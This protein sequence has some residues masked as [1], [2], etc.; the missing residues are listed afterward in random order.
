M[1]TGLI[2]QKLGMSAHFA[3]NGQHIPV[4]V[5]K[6]DNCQVVAQRTQEKDGYTAV[7]LGVG[8]AKVK[9]VSKPMR[10]H[11]AK[12][13]VEPKSQVVEFRVSDDA[14]IEVGTELTADHFVAGQYVDA[15]GTSQGKG[16]AG[17]M[18]RHGFSGLRAS[19]GVSISH[20]SHGSTGQ[21]QDPGKVFKGK[22]MAGH[23]G[24]AQVTTQ[25]LE[26]VSTDADR[27]IILVKGAVPGSKGG[28]ILLSDALKKPLPED[29]PMPAGIRGGATPAEEAPAEEAA[30]E[31]VAEEAVE[32]QE[33]APVEEVPV[34][35]TPAEEEAPAE[36]NADA[37]DDDA[38]SKD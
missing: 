15:V 29:V 23:M 4:T 13:K 21:C 26:I 37:S 6:L 25:S 27:G 1:R 38:E 35:E 31:E 30:P 36:D 11:F 2:A 34:E 10:G 14:M 5:L 12:S 18:K 22:K 7:Q 8:E 28:Y 24:D 33:E 16:F 17:A 32:A 9:N 19:H 3:D 20:R